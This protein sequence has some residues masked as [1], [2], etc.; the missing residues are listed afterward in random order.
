MKLPL[1]VL[2]LTALGP[3]TVLA[4][5]SYTTS[6]AVVSSNFDTLPTAGTNA[7]WANDSTIT[8]WNLFSSTGAALTT[9]DAGAGASNTGKYYSFGTGTATERALGSAASGGAYF[10]SPL[11]GAVAGWSAVALT[12]NSGGNLDIVTIRYDGEQW[13]NGGNATAQSLTLEYGIGNTFATVGTWTAPGGAFNFTGPIAT[14]TA[15]A[16]DG[17][18]AGK[19]TGL[20]GT[21]AGV[22][23]TSGSTLWVRWADLND[24]GNDHGLALDNVDISAVPEPST[25]ALAASALLFLRRRRA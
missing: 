5:I 9:I 1:P 17:N 11:T 13:R 4:T 14:A 7:A 20:G 24:V 3:S 21:I 18:G 6:G 19:V 15:A 2:I 12:N 23:W 10:G 25:G 22:P 8:G 16:V